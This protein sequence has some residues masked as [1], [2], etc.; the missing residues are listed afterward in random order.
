MQRAQRIVVATGAW[1]KELLTPLGI[2]VPLETERGYHALMPE[3]SI[4]LSIPVLVK[5]RGFG[6]TPME[7]GLCAAGTVEIGGLQ[8]PPNERRAMILAEH[9]KRLFPSLKTGEPTYWMGFR[10]SMPD[11]LPV[12]GATPGLPGL[13]LAFG[14]GHFGLTGGPPSARLVAQIING[15]KPGVDP[16]PYACT[17][18]S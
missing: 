1:S 11:S 4:K 16:A 17:R 12:L 5:N 8:A 2:D 3:P 13:Y 14:H 15:E 9:A 6:L 18:F 10:P 7:N